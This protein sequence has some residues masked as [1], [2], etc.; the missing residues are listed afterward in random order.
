LAGK[1]SVLNLTL[2][3]EGIKREIGYFVASESNQYFQ[4]VCEGNA[5]TTRS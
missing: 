4:P 2:A 3:G 5:S 1:D